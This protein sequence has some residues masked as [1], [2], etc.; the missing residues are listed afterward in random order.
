M[1]KEEKQG[2]EE[3]RRQ[4]K[5]IERRKQENL[6][7]L[8]EF[9]EMERET[10]EIIKLLKKFYGSYKYNEDECPNCGKRLGDNDSLCSSCGAKAR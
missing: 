4:Q 2:Q 5:E 6:K 1:K 3:Y 7:K 9:V 10:K 8:H